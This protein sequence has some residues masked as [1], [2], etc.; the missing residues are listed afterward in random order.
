MS[1]KYSAVRTSLRTAAIM[2]VFTVAFTAVM[3]FTYD[4]TRPAIEASV[5]EEQMRLINEVLPPDSYD[6][7]L[8]AD[9]ITVAGEQALGPDDVK[10][11]WRAR[12]AGTPVALILEAAAGNGY[13]GRIAFIVALR[14]DGTVIGVRVTNHK[15]TPGLGDYIDPKKDRNKKKPWITQFEGVSWSQVD[16][17]KWALRKDGG[18]F[19][20]H[21]GAT[22]SARAMTGAIARAVAFGVERADALFAADAGNKL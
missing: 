1:N 12:K 8:L 5:Q 11:V 7:D 13:A 14:P 19:D 16:N 22:I 18:T 4:A 6:N 2:I 10:R 9:A 15:E 20:Y 17:A 21:T 3:A